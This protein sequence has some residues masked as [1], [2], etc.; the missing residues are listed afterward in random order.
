MRL[1]FTVNLP[2]FFSLRIMIT[3]TIYICTTGEKQGT[4][5]PV[6]N[7]VKGTPTPTFTFEGV[8][9]RPNVPS[10]MSLCTYVRLSYKSSL[11]V[12]GSVSQIRTSSST[13]S[14][15]LLPFL[16]RQNFHLCFLN[17]KLTYS[18]S[19]F[20]SFVPEISSPDLLHFLLSR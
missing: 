13:L 8:P 3:L 4:P 19:Y 1:I 11:M 18:H 5:T 6:D 9:L 14:Q 15:L 2:I 20:P 17:V 12:V 10:L 7:R 16:R